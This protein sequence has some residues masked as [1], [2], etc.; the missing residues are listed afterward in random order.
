MP[1]VSICVLNVSKDMVK[2]YTDT[3]TVLQD[4]INVNRTVFNDS[5]DM[6]NVQEN[7]VHVYVDMINVSVDM[8]H[9]S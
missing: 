5:L 1:Q 3:P 2:L 7:I 6:L 8:D 9:E 4:L